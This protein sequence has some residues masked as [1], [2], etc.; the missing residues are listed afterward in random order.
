MAGGNCWHRPPLSPPCL[1]RSPTLQE[2]ATDNYLLSVF[3][4]TIPPSFLPTFGMRLS[5]IISK[6]DWPADLLSACT[7]SLLEFMEEIKCGVKVHFLLNS[8]SFQQNPTRLLVHTLSYSMPKR[9]QSTLLWISLAVKWRTI[10]QARRK[11][12]PPYVGLKGM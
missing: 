3:P 8:P 1:T 4:L 11:K 12:V 9:W 5:S 7:P 6:T 2:E 10:Q